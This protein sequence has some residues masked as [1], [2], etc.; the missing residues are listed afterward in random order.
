MTNTQDTGKYI[1]AIRMGGGVRLNG[2]TEKYYLGTGPNTTQYPIP[3]SEY[4]VSGPWAGGTVAGASVLVNGTAQPVFTAPNDSTSWQITAISARASTEAAAAAT[5]NVEVAAAA[6]APGSGTNQMSSAIPI[7]SGGTANTVANGTITTQTAIT[8]GMS[9]NLVPGGAST[10]SL[11]GL[12]V[13]IVL[14][15]LS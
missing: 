6:T 11:A 8:A 13:T 10:A 5:L 2:T 4:I 7:G 14:Q 12:V 1:T 9:V 3:T 15:R